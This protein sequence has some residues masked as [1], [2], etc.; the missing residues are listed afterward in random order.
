MG[1]FAAGFSATMASAA[2]DQVITERK[3]AINAILK[4]KGRNT[5]L[6]AYNPLPTALLD[7][8]DS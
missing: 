3:A 8:A 7:E 4:G 5:S 6:E 2:A 1:D